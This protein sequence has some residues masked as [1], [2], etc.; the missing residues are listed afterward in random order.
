LCYQRISFSVQTTSIQKSVLAQIYLE[1]RS[2]LMH[3]QH[4][5][6]ITSNTLTRCL[7]VGIAPAGI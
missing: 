4:A 7:W 5:L 6:A 2:I 3:F 1:V